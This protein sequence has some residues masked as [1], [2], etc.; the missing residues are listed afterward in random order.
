MR[1]TL[2]AVP[3]AAALVALS[4]PAAVV[5]GCA[6]PLEERFAG[7]PEL[8]HG[9]GRL[10]LQKCGRCHEPFPVARFSDAQWSRQVLAMRADANLSPDQERRIVG[11]LQAHN[12]P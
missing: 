11:Y 5:G 6:V 4:L 1:H 3:I 2:A 8:A 12:R 7:R 10:Y 9:D